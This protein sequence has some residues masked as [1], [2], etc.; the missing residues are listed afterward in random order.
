MPFPLGQPPSSLYGAGLRSK[1]IV[2]HL[3]FPSLRKGVSESRGG[4]F[5]SLFHCIGE[6]V[7]QEAGAEREFEETK[8]GKRPHPQVFLM[9]SEE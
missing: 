6:G 9:H 2:S 4:L 1:W 7:S 3:K 8:G 5:Q